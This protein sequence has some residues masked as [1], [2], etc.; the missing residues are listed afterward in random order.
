[1]TTEEKSI[2]STREL[3]NLIV[4]GAKE[5]KLEKIQFALQY[6]SID[7]KTTE[8][9]PAYRLAI[10]GTS[11][12]SEAIAF[13]LIH[14]PKERFVLNKSAIS[15]YAKIGNVDQVDSILAEAA[16]PIEKFELTL[17]ALPG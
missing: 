9:A 4:D 12:A 1:M 14:F 16:N 10:Q 7:V 5:K 15:A 3:F 6:V 13:L 8:G 11:E 17:V 2:P